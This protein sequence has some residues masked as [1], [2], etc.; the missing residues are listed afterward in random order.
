[1]GFRDRSWIRR[2]RRGCAATR[3]I[4]R[5]GPRSLGAQAFPVRPFRQTTKITRKRTGGR[6]AVGRHVACGR[7]RVVGPPELLRSHRKACLH[8]SRAA[9]A[10]LLGGDFTP[11]PDGVWRFAGASIIPNLYAHGNNRR[12]RFPRSWRHDPFDGMQTESPMAF[13]A[14]ALDERGTNIASSIRGGPPTAPLNWTSAPRARRV[15]QHERRNL[16]AS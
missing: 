9:G 5:F 12:T 13:L 8:L 16:P 14:E 4:P 11:D 15:T 3:V 1:M 10:P 6:A 2:R 7:T